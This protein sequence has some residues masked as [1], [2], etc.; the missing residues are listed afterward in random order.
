MMRRFYFVPLVLLIVLTAAG[1][2]HTFGIEFAA[3]AW[4]QSPAGKLG[5]EALDP[6]DILDLETDLNYQDETRFFG[7]IDI[8]MPIFIPN[9]YLV[10]TPMEFEGNGS[11]NFNFGGV[12]I[13]GDFYSKLTLNHLDV[14]LYYGIPLLEK[15]TLETFNIDI[16]LNV[17]IF[18]LEATATETSGSGVS[19]TESFTLPIPMVYL[20]VQIRPIEAIAIEA[21]GRGISISGNKAYS[22]IGRLR[23]NAVGP[24]FLAGGYRYDKYD[25]DEE[26]VILDADFS[27]PFGELGLSF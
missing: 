26:G 24:L 21:E 7:W 12:T 4:Q 5:Y 18:D 17:R 9:I 19:E 16:G 8:D 23:W 15:A 10:A 20:A 1:T 13:N 2:G 6:N 11:K 25:I 14:A 27:G 22:L 3:G